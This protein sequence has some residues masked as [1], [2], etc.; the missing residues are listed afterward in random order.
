MRR[1]ASTGN[2]SANMV[3]PV[4][5]SLLCLLTQEERDGLSPGAEGKKERRR[6]LRAIGSQNP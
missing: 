5:L 4:S 1:R 3:M 6:S 2:I